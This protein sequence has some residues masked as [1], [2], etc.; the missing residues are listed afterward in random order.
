MYFCSRKSIPTVPSS[1]KHNAPNNEIIPHTIHTTKQNP[2][3]PEYFRAAVGD[4][5]IP[6]PIITPII[7]L[8]AAIRPIPRLS[9]TVVFSSFVL[10]TAVEHK[11]I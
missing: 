1:A 4:T 10:T 11:Y 8:T 6:D 2:T 9:P 5:K 7:M 3:L